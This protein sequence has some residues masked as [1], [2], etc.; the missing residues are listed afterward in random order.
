MGVLGQQFCKRSCWTSF[1]RPIIFGK[2]SA[3]KRS[4]AP[5][6]YFFCLGEKSQF[7]QHLPQFLHHY[8]TSVMQV[9]NPK[10][11]NTCLNPTHTHFLLVDNGTDGKNGAEIFLRKN[12]ER[13]ISRQMRL[14][15]RGRRHGVPVVT[16][17]LEVSMVCKGKGI[18]LGKCDLRPGEDDTESQW[19]RLF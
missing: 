16:V 4:H 9:N 12:L 15:T 14:T 11:A 2:D 13:H 7:C 10:S 3:K 6:P 19:S 5:L 17:V 18:S 8:S 1:N